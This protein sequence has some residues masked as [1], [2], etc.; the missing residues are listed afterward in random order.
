MAGLARTALA[1]GFRSRSPRRARTYTTWWVWHHHV[2]AQA[3]PCAHQTAGDPSA[4]PPPDQRGISRSSRTA[5][6]LTRRCIGCQ[7]PPPWRHHTSINHLKDGRP[8]GPSITHKTSA[9][10]LG[11]CLCAFGGL[12][13]LSMQ[14]QNQAQNQERDTNAHD[15]GVAMAI[16][17]L[18]MHDPELHTII[19][20]IRTHR[21]IDRSSGP[22]PARETNEVARFNK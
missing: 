9:R 18:D 15:H 12:R 4:P 20:T 13:S 22:G 2:V 8:A 14:R 7:L 6:P 1:R 17:K 3:P 21:S 16:S 19:T 11:S 10:S 5:G